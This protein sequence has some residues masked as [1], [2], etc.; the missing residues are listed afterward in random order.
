MLFTYLPIN[1]I[2][3]CYL[4]VFYMIQYYLN[5]IDWWKSTNTNSWQLYLFLSYVTHVIVSLQ[6]IIHFV[7]CLKRM[8]HQNNL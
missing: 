1:K 3:N 6:V 7:K 4:Y 2:F 8:S 5:P